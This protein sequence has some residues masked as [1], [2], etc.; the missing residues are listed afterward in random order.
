MISVYIHTHKI[1]LVIVKTM[2]PNTKDAKKNLNISL[3]QL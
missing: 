1:M 3:K 2:Y